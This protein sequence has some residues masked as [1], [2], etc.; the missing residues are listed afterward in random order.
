LPALKK[1]KYE[2]L[3]PHQQKSNR[4]FIGWQLPN[5]VFTPKKSNYFLTARLK[6]F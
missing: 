2:F 6:H 5:L 1:R 3:P 4:F